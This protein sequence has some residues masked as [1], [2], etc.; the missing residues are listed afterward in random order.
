[1][2]F[3]RFIQMLSRIDRIGESFRLTGRQNNASGFI[4]EITGFVSRCSAAVPGFHADK[5]GVRIA[6][7]PEGK[8]GKSGKFH[9]HTM[10]CLKVQQ[11]DRF[12]R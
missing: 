4:R 2:E 6:L 11:A 5:G 8:H 9:A 10:A 3:K 7:C 1:M 12:D